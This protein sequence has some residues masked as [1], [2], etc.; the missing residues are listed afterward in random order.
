MVSLYNIVMNQRHFSHLLSG[1][2]S[3]DKVLL[4]PKSRILDFQSG[5]GC[6]AAY[7]VSVSLMMSHL[8]ANASNTVVIID[9]LNPFPLS[10]I[11]SHPSYRPEWLDTNIISYTV[12]TFAKLYALFTFDVLPKDKSGGSTMIFI[13]DIHETFELYKYELSA[14]YEETILKHHIERNAIMI[15]NQEQFELMGT[16]TPLP[17][18]PA[19]SDLLRVSPVAKFESHLH[20]LLNEISTHVI[21]NNLFCILLGHLDTKYEFW[22]KTSQSSQTSSSGRVVLTDSLGGKYQSLTG[23]KTAKTNSPLDTFVTSRLIFYRDWYHKSPH[24]KKNFPPLTPTSR[25]AL[26]DSNLRMVFVVQVKHLQEVVST[27]YPPIYFDHDNEYYHLDD[28]FEVSSNPAHFQFIDLSTDKGA[29]SMARNGTVVDEN[30]EKA[31]PPSSPNISVDSTANETPE[32]ISTANGNIPEDIATANQSIP[33][34]ISIANDNTLT[35]DIPTNGNELN[36]PKE[37]VE[38]DLV[39]EESED[40]IIGTLL[41]K[42]GDTQI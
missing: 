26:N 40:E 18:L 28:E 3:L 41:E 16:K 27:R 34:D 32:D 30:T 25:V 1:I 35:E 6:I 33:D 24:F 12:D 20:S 17:D 14:L 21:N 22:S 5:P 31:F 11:T 37:D 29:T 36:I 9:T 4:S 42:Q 19:N 13:N 23:G 8:T 10:L 39:V 38:D 7:T 15:R 2:P